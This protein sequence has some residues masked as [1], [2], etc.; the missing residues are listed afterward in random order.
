MNI[1]MYILILLIKELNNTKIGTKVN[2]I[3]IFFGELFY[4]FTIEIYNRIL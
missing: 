2:I 3:I 1:N 4:V